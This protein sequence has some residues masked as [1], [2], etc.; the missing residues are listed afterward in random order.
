MKDNKA[1]EALER[2][3]SFFENLPMRDVGVF[4]V[5]GREH[6]GNNLTAIRSALVELAEIKKRAE[7]WKGKKNLQKH[8]EVE[9]D[10]IVEIIDYILKGNVTMEDIRS[11]VRSLKGEPK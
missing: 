6:N 4:S 8:G 1:L 2:I 11:A 7:E 9:Y 3:E 5:E 10:E